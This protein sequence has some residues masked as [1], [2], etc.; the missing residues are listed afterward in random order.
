MGLMRKRKLPLL[1]ILSYFSTLKQDVVDL[2]HTISQAD[3]QLN[4][5]AWVD[6]ASKNLF[7]L[8]VAT[9]LIKLNHRGKVCTLMTKNFKASVG[10]RLFFLLP[11]AVFAFTGPSWK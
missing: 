9:N 2:Q 4:P 1:G 3:D 10:V 5:Q 7:T 11:L 6:S 8:E